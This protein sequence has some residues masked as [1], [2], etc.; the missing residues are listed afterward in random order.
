MLRD[1]ILPVIAFVFALFGSAGATNDTVRVEGGLISVSVVDEVRIHKGIPFAAP[2]MS[3]LR[4]K[5]PQPVAAWEGVRK[6]D[7][8]GPDCPQEPYPQSSLYYSAPHKQSEDC[9]YLNVWTAARVGEKPPV[10]VWIHGDAQMR[11]SGATRAY[12]GTALA[13]KGGVPVTINYRLGPL[14]YLAHPELTADRRSFLT[15]TAQVGGMATATIFI[16]GLLRAGYADTAN[17]VTPVV[18]IKSGKVR[19]RKENGL[20]VFKGIPYGAP[21]GSANRFM[22]RKAPEPW[23]GVRGAV[24]I[25]HYAPQSNR[26]RGQKQRQFFA[27]LRPA[28]SNQFHISYAMRHMKYGAWHIVKDESNLRRKSHER[29]TQ[30]DRIV[31]HRRR[32]VVC[33]NGERAGKPLPVSRHDLHSRRSLL[34]LS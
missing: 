34:A 4:W 28:P 26:P 32:A 1:L 21:T 9:L 13:K 17:G 22:P 15:A 8:F 16:P 23:T 14:G 18:T 6:C 5:A 11:G 7:D 3:E 12:D 25:G 27:L 30:F 19:G 29:V 2:P 31:S 20:H 10:I 24:E 33:E